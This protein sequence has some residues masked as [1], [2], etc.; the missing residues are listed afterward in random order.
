MNARRVRIIASI[1]VPAL[2][3]LL[4]LVVYLVDRTANEG[5]VPR[6][7]SV[8]G[9][10]VGGLSKDDAIVVVRAYEENLQTQPATFV[11]SGSSYDLDPTTVALTADVD[12]A[13]TEA[14]TQ[15]SGGVFSGFVPWLNGFTERVDIDLAISI[16]DDAVDAHLDDWELD[17]IKNPA[18]E[19]AIEVVDGAIEFEYP[20]IGERIDMPT[21]HT[22]VNS[23]LIQPQ[24]ET[25][26]LP[27]I[28]SI[29]VMTRAAVDDAVVTL[30]TMVSRPVL[31]HDED[32]NLVL[33]IKPSEIADATIVELV[34]ESP[35]QVDISLS[36]DRVAEILEPH[37]PD[38]E[39][40]PVNADF[41]VD[42]E[43]DKVSIIPSKNATILDPEGVAIELLSAA[44][45]GTASGS[46]V[47][48]EGVDPRFTTAD[49]EGFGPLDLVS[50]FTTKTPGVN[51]VHN[52]HLMADTIDGY[53]VWPG[54]EFSINEVVGQ[55]TE[56][57]G[58]KRDG[59]IVNGQVTCCDDPVNVGGGVSQ[60][61][62]TIYNAIFFGCYEDIEHSPHSLYISRY[63]EG[64]E[65]TMGFP[66]PDVVFR[67]DS[68]APVII[69]NSYDGDSTITVQFYGNNG[70]R[71]CES[72]RS[73]RFNYTDPKTV[74]EANTSVRPG[75]QRVVSK[76]SQG[77][78]VTVTRVMTMPDGSVIREPYTHRY[79][80][81]ARVIEKH[82]CN[83]GIGSCPVPATTTT[84]APAPTTTVAPT[85]TAAPPPPT[86]E[87]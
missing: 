10:D 59:A 17:A 21:A 77:W 40:P 6:N 73:E 71:I 53:V 69:R 44:T 47:Y 42:I 61:A 55:R 58:Y 23:V 15:R 22:I 45:S 63:P 82:P 70:G 2:L 34:Q 65:A 20:R 49:A 68:D 83:L 7:V 60:Y 66:S 79:R 62:T 16:D 48:T 72:E 13:V 41:D 87:G 67:N 84:Q 14:L 33:T 18:Y 5:E 81:A 37:R 3:L 4:P 35:A 57:K 8:A 29:P 56:A 1:A 24:R 11:V 78:S 51:R 85:T 9:V 27:L 32:R 52:I 86:E 50:E 19:G 28:D 75:S 80:G 36:V 76:G 64:R 30:E 74:Y 25:T 12:G 46:L 43:T 54:D 31:L 39:L 26:E 38:F